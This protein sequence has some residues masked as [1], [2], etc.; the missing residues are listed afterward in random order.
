MRA[1]WHRLLESG[2]L[3]F[4]ERTLR[5]SWWLGL[6]LLTSCLEAPLP[7]LP[8]GVTLTVRGHQEVTILGDGTLLPRWLGNR[9][10]AGLCLDTP[11]SLDTSQWQAQLRF[12]GHSQDGE[13]GA[14]LGFRGP[15]ARAGSALCFYQQL[16]KD[17]PPADSLEICATVRDEFDQS[18]YQLPC[19]EAHWQPDDSEF[20]AFLRRG[21]G[22]IGQGEELTEAENLRRLDDLASEAEDRR[23]HFL[24]LRL[25]LVIVEA[26]RQRGDEANREEIH[27]RLTSLPEWLAEPE[28]AAQASRVLYERAAGEMTAGDHRKAWGRLLQAE[29][30]ARSVAA[31]VRLAIV[32]KQAEI[33]HLRGQNPQAAALLRRALEECEHWPCSPGLETGAHGA[34]AW[35]LLVDPGSSREDLEAAG[36]HLAAQLEG[37][38]IRPSEKANILINRAFLH[39]RTGRAPGPTLEKARELLRS[40]TAG[41]RVASLGAWAEIVEGLW[42]LDRGAWQEAKAH[43]HRAVGRVSSPPDGAAAPVG[44]LSQ[45]LAW[46]WSCLGQARRGEADPEG[47]LE[48]FEQA[49]VHHALISPDVSEGLPM[50]PGQEVD[51]Y[52]RAA[53]AAVEMGE[54]EYA[55]H[56]LET[57]DLQAAEFRE[58]C[59][60]RLVSGNPELESRRQDL[61][62]RLSWTEPPLAPD[63]SQ[64][65]KPVRWSLLQALEGLHRSLL[66]AC[67]EPSGTG[68]GGSGE[69]SAQ[70]G[71]EFRRPAYFQSTAPADF[72]VFAL[73]DE[74]LLL[75]RQDD[76]RIDVRRTPWSRQEL[77]RLLQ[78]VARAQRAGSV[79][80]G[81]VDSSQD[82]Q[83][84]RV[85]AQPLARALA[86]LN[87]SSG[88]PQPLG[89]V[90]RY[91][92][93]GPLQTIPLAALPVR[94]LGE[95]RWLG[96]VTTVV[97]HP[98]WVVS[99]RPVESATPLGRP[100][101][102]VDPTLT[103]P[104]GRG[105]GDQFR[106]LYPGASFLEG[107]AATRSAVAEALGAASFVHIDSHGH[108]DAAFPTLS[109]LDLHDGRLTLGDF[110]TSGFPRGL[111]NLSGCFTGTGTETG[112]SSLYGL[113]GILAQRGVSWVVASH[114]AVSDRLLADFNQGFYQNLTKGEGVPA[115]FR[116]AMGEIRGT[117]PA[118]AW[119]NLVL[120]GSG[121]SDLGAKELT[122]GL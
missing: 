79:M 54:A 121:F 78:E 117:Y 55:W 99:R 52:Y 14:G 59:G 20:V 33:L 77:R 2:P 40:S 61:L 95:E 111:V 45:D 96:E 87:F 105:Q 1:F 75:G 94:V 98:P 81:Q 72:R 31:R 120:V 112:G 3:R 60:D 29:K 25:R 10:P 30:T 63:R 119:S 69:G 47:A 42:A 101:F 34:L 4:F 24:A 116:L 58:G 41:Q 115:S 90:T 26:L 108:F 44:T 92:L 82:S 21:Q 103:L 66:V 80:G 13:K 100:L 49:L 73:P 56:L 8:P 74:V 122:L 12:N 76:G 18:R 118:A 36:E 107:S 57:L 11:L 48:A 7:G 114:S 43:C 104:S 65:L 62:Q 88:A 9:Q 39:R 27:R 84:W 93:H 32:L 89:Q 15:S 67:S 97:L 6:P 68:T 71:S 109:G 5:L 50:V 85:L 110:L 19:I 46:A 106:D 64:Q 91:A 53:R 23:F 35:Y 37:S 16:P 28:A 51:D 113:A 86:P 38:E 22:L 102:V 70:P 17:L 83:A